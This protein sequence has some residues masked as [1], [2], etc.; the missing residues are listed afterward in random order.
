MFRFKS[1]ADPVKTDPESLTFSS[2]VGFI[3]VK[4]R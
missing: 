2:A 4:Q 1:Y 3:D